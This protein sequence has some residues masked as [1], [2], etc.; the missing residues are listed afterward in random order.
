MTAL[1]IDCDTHY[2]EPISLWAEY[3]EP[4]F[5]DRAPRLVS[6]GDRLLLQ[7]GEHVYPSVPHHQGLAAVYGPDASL[8]EQI[9]ADKALSL[10]ASQR[11]SHMDAESTLAQVIYPTLG[12]IGF[13]GIEDP[14]LAGACAR[15][16]NRFT[17][18][19]AAA[20]PK[21]L[22]TT[23]LVP[24]NHPEVAASEMRFAKSELG[25]DIVFT[26]PTPPG[27]HAWSDARFDVIWSAASD[28]EVAVTFHESTVGAGPNAVGINRYAGRAPMIYLCTHTVEVQLAVM[29]LILGGVLERHPALRV[30]LLEAHLTWIPGWLQL[31]DAKFGVTTPQLPSDY[32]RR[33][34]FSAA[35][36]E[37]PGVREMIDAVGLDNV[38]FASDWPH[39]NLVPGDHSG[40][41]DIVGT[42]TDLTDEEKVALLEHNPCRWLN[43]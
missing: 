19:F 38:V 33:C 27:D 22:R 9:R 26:N 36:P 39:P 14:E 43:L 40:W 1:A 37:D 34:I 41:V 42:R 20:D 18:D 25:L 21:R 3:L 24:F 13:S 29:D 28:L 32:F 30:G 16:Y 35:F 31:M 2:W 23:M 4:R 5:A 11:L 15:A 10:D 12:M 6:D 7:V 17:A 8:R